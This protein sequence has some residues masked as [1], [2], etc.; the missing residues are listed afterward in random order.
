MDTLIRRR[1]PLC[2]IWVCTVRLCLTKR[3]LDL[4][5]KSFCLFPYFV[6]HVVVVQESLMLAI[7]FLGYFFSRTLA[8]LASNCSWRNSQFIGIKFTVLP[9]PP[10]CWNI[11]KS[12][13]TRM[14][15]DICK[16]V[17]QIIRFTCIST[18]QLSGNN[19]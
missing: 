3:T 7:F 16:V 18:R 10:S 14:D 17:S 1:V 4:Y 8:C 2:L 19:Y 15:L 5:E 12:I 11:R 6:F 13:L 9:F